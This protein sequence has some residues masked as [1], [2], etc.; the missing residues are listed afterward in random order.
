MATQP[1][2]SME[3]TL[4]TTNMESDVRS[5][6]SPFWLQMWRKTSWCANRPDLTLCCKTSRFQYRS[7]ISSSQRVSRLFITTSLKS[8]R[9]T[10]KEDQMMAARQSLSKGQTWRLSKKTMPSLTTVNWLS[11]S[12]SRSAFVLKRKCTITRCYHAN[13]PHTT[14]R[15]GLSL[16]SQSI[17]KSS[18]M[19]TLRSSTIDRRSSTMF[20]RGKDQSKAVL[21]WRLA[22]QTFPAL[23]LLIVCSVTH[24]SLQERSSLTRRSSVFLLQFLVLVGMN[25]KFPRKKTTGLN[26]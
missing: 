3:A 1:S 11:V 17:I 25:W 12:S 20:S 14:A 15:A 18:Q 23:K 2:E 26:Q 6:P 21:S 16:R 4:R 22:V 9:L 24:T 19:T 13:H 8:F 5:V 10:R 7:T